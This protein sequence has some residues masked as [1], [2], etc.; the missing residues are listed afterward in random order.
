MH[1]IR[2][3]DFRLDGARLVALQDGEKGAAEVAGQRPFSA[4]S[5]FIEAVD[6]QVRADEI[7]RLHLPY[8]KAYPV[9]GGV[10]LLGG[11]HWLEKAVGQMAEN[12]RANEA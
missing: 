9:T 5:L 6:A 1:E 2:T 8:V 12:R 10:W 4:H 11:H 7:E 3:R